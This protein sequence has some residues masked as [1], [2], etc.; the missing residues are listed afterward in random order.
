MS[1][2]ERDEGQDP[3]PLAPEAT[4][5]DAPSHEFKVGYGRPPVHSRFK[6]GSSGNSKGRPQGRR[7]IKTV[8]ERVLNEKVTVRENGKPR[9]T[10]KFEAM[11]QRH[12]SK[13][14]QGDARS[15]NTIVGFLGRT[16]HLSETEL[17]T[18]TSS[19]PEDD[20]E[21][22]RNYFRREIDVADPSTSNDPEAK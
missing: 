18:S 20:A 2:N 19:L 1:K 14:M 13:A 10:T 7:N 16:G 9:K 6:P 4:S 15:W 12:T 8:V 21:I 11:F 17:E 3:I 5:A 22:I